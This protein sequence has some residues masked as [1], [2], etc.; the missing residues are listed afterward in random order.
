MIRQWYEPLNF[1]ERLK[2]TFSFLNI[3]I[4]MV[5]AIF[6]FSEFRFDW[7]ENLVGTYLASTNDLRPET[8]AVWEAGK[9]TS[10]AH[11]SLNKIISKKEDTRQTVHQAST[12]SFLASSIVPGEWVTLEKQQFK[13]LYLA[14]EKSTALKI[15]EPAQLVWLLKGSSLDRIFCEGIIGG[16]K[17]YFIDSENRVIKQIDLKKEDILEIENGDKPV[18]GKLADMAGFSGRTYPARNFFDALFKLPPD[19]IP[20]LIVNPEA[21]LAQEGKITRVGIWNEAENGYIKLGFEFQEKNSTQVVFVKGREWAV[22]QVS[23]NLKG[24]EN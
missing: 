14:L 19:M 7:A 4:F 2:R 22:W 13:S 23:L 3:A 16:I 20:D 12:F 11:E 1:S 8:G 18:S 5:T 6:V 9:Q 15:I 17:I 21:L 10:S 24:E